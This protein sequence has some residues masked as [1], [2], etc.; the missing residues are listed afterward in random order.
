MPISL[1][2]SLS[3]TGSLT[4]S[5][6]MIYSG[7]VVSSQPITASAFLTTG[8]ITAQTLVVSTISSS[9][10]Y[11][12]GSNIF[13]SSQ[14][15]RQTFTGSLYITGSVAS[16]S[17]CVGI[18]TLT[19]AYA[20]DVYNTTANVAMRLF[21]P[22]V[23]T[24]DYNSMYITGNHT[25]VIGY[26]GS[27]GSTTPN[28]S[29]QNSLY[30]GVQNAY[31][32][33]F[34]TS[35]VVR[36]TISGTGGACFA[37]QVC[38]PQIH[39]NSTSTQLTLQNTDGGTNAE[40]IGMFMTGGDTFKI[41]SLCDNGN[42]RVDNILVANVLNGN[43]GIGTASP[44]QLFE[45]VGGEIKAG[46]VDSTNEGG[47]LSFGRACDNATGWYLDVYGNTSTP[48]LRFVDVSNSSVRMIINGSGITCFQGTVCLPKIAYNGYNGITA[49]DLIGHFD[50]GST[51]IA[52]L[53]DCNAYTRVAAHIEWVSNY[54]LAGTNMTMGYTIV[55]TRRGNS[56][57]IWVK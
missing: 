28:A 29:L 16:F 42:T 4:V 7:S 9:V 19:P 18:G 34:A 52:T 23:S 53:S 25:C 41:L 54:A 43:V 51:N 14:S 35:D 17:G 26:I 11:A 15:N 10:E 30:M 8:T 37:C 56:N 49:Y 47:Q 44:S 12:S 39:I 21:Q 38:T 50:A 13:G 1:S 45:V 6:S 20:L 24:S 27:A 36:V 5:G 57:T 55:D 33:K 48:S 2:G 31:P 32:L 46:R 22:S 40:R 3:L